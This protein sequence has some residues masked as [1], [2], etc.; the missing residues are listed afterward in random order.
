MDHF[1]ETDVSRIIL[2][3]YHAKFAKA[4]CSDVAIV[5]AGPSGL[6]A[7]WKLAQAGRQVVVLEKRLS[8]GGGVWG[9]AIGMNDVVIQPEALAIL[10]AA[11]VQHQPAGRLHVADAMELACALCIKAK[12]AG[13]IILNLM[14]VEDICVRN[15]RVNGVVANRTMLGESL[16]IDPIVFGAKAVID[17][18]GHDAMLVECL[19]SRG[20]LDE[21]GVEGPMNAHAGEQFV[22]K[23]VA[24]IFPGLWTT[25][26]CVCASQGGPRMGPIFGGMLLSGQSVARQ[27]LDSLAKPGDSRPAAAA[28]PQA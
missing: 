15:G 5:G 14:A 21:M 22:I 26:M 18:T 7:A 10:D 12:Q 24:E 2:E 23:N 13:A 11:G 9:G 25:G 8:P 27:V 17:A 6:V 20:L 3:T 1:E 16:P 28:M 4:L 19:Q